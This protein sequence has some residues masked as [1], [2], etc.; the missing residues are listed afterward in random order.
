LIKKEDWFLDTTNIYTDL[1][2]GF[3]E[4]YSYSNYTLT[5]QNKGNT[6]LYIE[7]IITSE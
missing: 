1:N 2:L 4:L 6:D 5:L 7:N 3:V